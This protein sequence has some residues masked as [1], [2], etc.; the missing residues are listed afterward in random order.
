MTLNGNAVYSGTR[1][2]LTDG[3]TFEGASAFYST[4]INVQNFTSNFSFQLTNPGGDGMTFIIQG[5][6]PTALGANGQNLGF[7]GMGNSV[8]VKF[9]LYN[10]GG[11]GNDSTGLY[12]M[13]ATPTIPAIDMTSSGVNL[14]SGD[15]FNVR[16]TYNGSTLTMTIT[17]AS[18]TAD[19]FTTSWT[20]NIPGIVGSTTAYVGFTGGTGGATAT[21]DVLT[22]TFN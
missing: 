8:A 9:D 16:M 7:G 12:T 15:V 14:H 10:N 17:D 20:V 5:N 18:N 22:W 13:G 4:P 11:E 1:L 3:G 2:R 21:Q 19:T 6:G